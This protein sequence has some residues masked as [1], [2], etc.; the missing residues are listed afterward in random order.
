AQVFGAEPLDFVLF[1][2]SMNSFFKSSGQSNYVAGCTFKD[3]FAHQLAREWPCQVKVMNWGYWGS[4]GIVASDTYKKRM[5]Q[6]GIGSIEPA[7]AMEALEAL[8]A[9]SLNQVALLKV[10][11]SK[12]LNGMR[13]E[14]SI[15]LYP[16][17]SNVKIES[18]SL[19]NRIVM[20]SIPIQNDASYFSIE[21][22]NITTQSV[23]ETVKNTLMCIAAEVI[24]VKREDID[25][26]TE[27]SEY[28]FDSIK[29]DEL[30]KRIN[31]RYH[32][33]ITATLFLEH[34][35]LTSFGE[36]LVEQFEQC[37]KA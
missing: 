3:A 16:E 6:A 22:G 26:D 25:P 24:N 20:P 31:Q 13:F 15:Q 29:L 35:T 9:G 12:A 2:S 36:Y 14:G 10:R 11:N 5:A 27:L 4:V 32:L 17:Q 1:F 28:G 18:K 7:E 21:E 23:T 34:S 30:S 8:L 37:L 19:R 33:E